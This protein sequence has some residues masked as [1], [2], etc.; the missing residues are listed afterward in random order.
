FADLLFATGTTT[1]ATHLA[2]LEHVARPQVVPTMQPCK[3]HHDPALVCNRCVEADEVVATGCEGPLCRQVAADMVVYRP[4]AKVSEVR[5][6]CSGHRDA[7]TARDPVT[8]TQVF[9][10]AKGTHNYL[11]YG[12]GTEIAT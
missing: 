9:P 11:A 4:E 8:R 7:F 5:A 10:I 12:D 2:E 3:R 6:L 1:S